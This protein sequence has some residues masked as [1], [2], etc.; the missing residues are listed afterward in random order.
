MNWLDYREQLGIGFND[1]QKTQYFLTK[2]F[3]ILENIKTEM[4]IQISESEYYK[5]CNTT[6]TPMQHG[7]LYG[8]GYGLILSTIKNKSHSLKEF[9]AYYMA[10]VNC[11]EDNRPKRWKKEDFKNLFTMLLYEIHIPFDLLE[12][13][14]G[15]FLFP[16]GANELDNPLVTQTLIWLNDYPLTKKAWTKALKD[17]SEAT[18]LT[19]SETADNFRK[20][21]ERFFQEFFSSDK[22]LENLKS[23][24]GSFLSS[25]D[26]PA[27]LRNNFENLLEAYTRYMNNYAK[28]HD[29]TSKSLL[30]Y[31][32]YQTGNI[33]RLM[34]TLR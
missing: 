33:I 14:E 15:Y 18:E 8:N 34:I 29:K 23:E 28:H 19:A 17:Y 4:Y 32:M 10:F 26:V 7:E 31:I 22:T 25:K 13:S 5:F 12:D 3:N 2:M 24:Y 1:E 27:E 30:E 9:T 21:L 20:A 11:Q 6:G 16:K